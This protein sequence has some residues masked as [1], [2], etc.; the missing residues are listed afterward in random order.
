LGGD[1]QP[2]YLC[3]HHTSNARV[4]R[5]FYSEFQNRQCKTE[6]LHDMS[7]ANSNNESSETENPAAL[8]SHFVDV[9]P[10]FVSVSSGGAT[11]H[12]SHSWLGDRFVI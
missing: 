10:N 1:V 9:E 8:F 11:S 4:S 7:W 5:I 6:G 3:P 12:S 2:L